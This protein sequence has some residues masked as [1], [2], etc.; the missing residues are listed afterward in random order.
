MLDVGRLVP[1][2]AKWCR[3][4]ERAV[5]LDKKFIKRYDPGRVAQVLRLL[6]SDIACERY[7]KPKLHQFLR[8]RRR[9]AEAMHDSSAKAVVRTFVRQQIDGFVICVTAVNDDRQVEL[10]GLSNLSA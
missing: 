4:Q 7:Q 3:C 1:L 2:P 10:A 9:P 6:E 8:H 5:G